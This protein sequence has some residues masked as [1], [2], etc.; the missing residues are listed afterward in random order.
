[1]DVIRTKEMTTRAG[2]GLKRL[3]RRIKQKIFEWLD[4]STTRP[5]SKD[6]LT[7]FHSDRYL[8]YNQRV[9]EHLAALQLDIAG[10]NVLEVGAG[11][12]DHTTFFLDRRCRVVTT[13][14]RQDNLDLLK[15]RYPKLE[16]SYLDLDSPDPAFNDTFEIVYCYGVLYHLS[17]PA[18]AIAFLAKHCSGLL[19]LQSCVSLGDDASINPCP[20]PSDDPSQAV[21]GIGCRPTRRWIYEELKRHF[22]F[23]YLPTTQPNHDEF[24]LDWSIKDSRQLT[25]AI[26]VGARYK[27]DNKQLT[28]ELLTRQT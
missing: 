12:G 27:V 24:P 13:D 8:R 7:H 11:I 2:S 9:Q 17:K 28:E 25:R 16:V 1:M 15:E 3:L 4:Q 23:V 26:F 18:E 22:E 19:L 6:P 21:S 10:S 14:A 20:E 5:G